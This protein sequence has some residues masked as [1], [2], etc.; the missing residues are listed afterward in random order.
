[1]HR[2]RGSN[3]SGGINLKNPSTLFF[4]GSRLIVIANYDE[5]R[6][7][8]LTS[9][10]GWVQKIIENTRQEHWFNMLGLAIVAYFMPM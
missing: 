6:P 7:H 8:S 5:S 9:W 1:M 2:V 10:W 3:D 4:L